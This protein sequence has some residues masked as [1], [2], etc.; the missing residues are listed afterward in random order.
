[1][2]PSIRAAA[3]AVAIFVAISLTGCGSQNVS[4]DSASVKC[5]DFLKMSPSDQSLYD[6]DRGNIITYTSEGASSEAWIKAARRQC[7]LKGNSNKTPK[8]VIAAI[9]QG[10]CSTF[11]TLSLKAKAEWADAT[12]QEGGW[13]SA[14]LTNEQK[15]L[16]M[17]KMCA[18]TSADTV[19]LAASG[20]GGLSSNPIVFAQFVGKDAGW[21]G[22]T[23]TTS[24]VLGYTSQG[25]LT[26]GPTLPKGEKFHPLNLKLSVG[27]A[28]A[29]NP[30]LDAVFPALF[31]AT[32]TTA[33][34]K[35]VVSGSISVQQTNAPGIT[36]A[37]AEMIF[38]DGT[39]ACSDKTGGTVG[40][41]SG[42]KLDPGN[43]VTTPTFIIV[44]NYYAPRYPSGASVELSRFEIR[45]GLSLGGEDPDASVT[46]A[47]IN[48]S[49]VH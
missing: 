29:F 48:L 16:A 4:R 13:S 10:T 23:W 6:P 2:K 21:S 5:A 26:I 31:V 9:S 25:R 33:N 27:T 28:C 30:D 22:I 34:T 1:M 40:E 43:S 35:A 49:A 41:Q 7:A 38:T 11:A 47:D 3:V 44:H 37:V 46:S 42:T 20:L 8:S 18:K 36:D 19:D 12:Q 14:G 15:A 32:G 39:S 17:T 24:T 45:P